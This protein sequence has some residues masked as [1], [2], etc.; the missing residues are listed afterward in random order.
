M[1]CSEAITSLRHVV[2]GVLLATFNFISSI[3]NIYYLYKEEH[4]L[5]GSLDLFLLWF[6]G[7][8]IFTSLVY[9]YQMDDNL[10]QMKKSHF[11]ILAWAI[12]IFCPLVP[13]VLTLAYIWTK[14]EDI[15]HKA[16]L[17]KCLAGFLDHGP[18]FVLRLVIVVLIGISH[19]G[20]YKR[21]DFIFIFS[22]V[23]SFLAFILTALIFN[24][25][26]SSVAKWLF[27]S[28]PMYSAIF[29][30]RAFTLAVFLKETLH[31]EKTDAPWAFFILLIMLSF[32]IGLFRWC[33]QDWLRSCLFGITSILV[34][35]GFNNDSMYYQVP[36]QKIT[37]D[38][39]KVYKI[40]NNQKNDNTEEPIEDDNDQSSAVLTP[41]KSTKFFII[42]VV[43]NTVLMFSV[44]SFLFT[45]ATDLDSNSDDAL[46]IPQ[47]L[48]VVP[49]MFFS[50][51]QCFT[52][53]DC[54]PDTVEGGNKCGVCC[55]RL[56]HSG[57]M[58]LA[59]IFS[60]L[61]FLSLAPALLWT[62]IYKWFTSFD[63]KTVMLD[64]ANDT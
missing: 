20:V 14:N 1:S 40:A 50:I 42:H 8:T 32:N 12:L 9:L 62:F 10:V 46:V 31:N 58:C 44:S 27:L 45:T 38:T 64:Y 4:Y 55:G 26:K 49:G 51:G 36:G 24:E 43:F 5:F 3:I 35:S 39:S 15:H 19:S 60:I 63:V 56:K 18:H 16:R 23:T 59:I 34:P 61:G 13:I 37:L 29:A 47:L 30:C 53:H 2:L 52:L 21:D 57:K 17:S 25:R 11:W 28:G 41:M 22:M 33:G 7:L 6:P 54:C 48:G